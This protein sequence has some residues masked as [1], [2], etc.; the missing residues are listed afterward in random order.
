M[1]D[2][3]EILISLKQESNVIKNKKLNS[4]KKRNIFIIV[5]VL[6]DYDR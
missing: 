2:N 6:I 1:R 5:R 4:Q 3:Y